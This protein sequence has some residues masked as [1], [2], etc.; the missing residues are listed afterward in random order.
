MVATRRGVRVSSPTTTNVEQPSDAKATP[1]TGRTRSAASRSD[2]PTVNVLVENSGQLQETDVATSLWTSTL[3]RCTRASRLH[4]PEQPCTPVGSIHEADVSDLE[5]CCSDM[6]AR[7]RCSSRR[8]PPSKANQEQET[9]ESCSSP[10]QENV[11]S[12]RKTAAASVEAADKKV[13]SSSSIVSDGEAP[14]KR[15]RR[16][17]RVNQAEEEASE[18][19]SCAS[20]VSATRTRRST[21]RRPI[22]DPQQEGE[23]KDNKVD[24]VP[25]TAE[26]YQSRRKSVCTRRSAKGQQED[27]ELSDAESNASSVLDAS[28]SA[29]RRSTRIRKPICPIP[30]NLD[31]VSVS[32]PTLRRTRR[33]KTTAAEKSCDSESFDSGPDYSVS[34][35]AKTRSSRSKTTESDSDLTEGSG[36]PCSSRTGSGSSL[37]RAPASVMKDLVVVLENTVEECMMDNSVL[38]S[39]VVA[40]DADGTLLDKDATEA[41]EEQDKKVSEDLSEAAQVEDPLEDEK[42]KATRRGDAMLVESSKDVEEVLVRDSVSAAAVVLTSKRGEPSAEEN[43]DENTSPVEVMEEREPSSTEMKREDAPN[44]G[45][46]LAEEHSVS[47]AAVASTDQQGELSAEETKEGDTSAVEGMEETE[48]SSTQTRCEDVPGKKAEKDEIINI[49]T[50]TSCDVSANHEMEDMDMDRPVIQAAEATPKAPPKRKKAAHKTFSL[51][52]SS[53]DDDDEVEEEDDDD[54]SEEEQDGGERRS[55]SRKPKDTVASV[56]G[57]FMVDTR[58][59]EEVDED[60]LL[61]R[62]TKEELVGGKDDEEEEFVDEEGDDNG[63]ADLNLSSKNRWLKKMS[64]CIDP[65]INMKQLGGLYITFDGSKSNS[66]PST[67]KKQKQKKV[68]DEVMKKSVMGPDFEKKD[69]VPPYSESK[70]VLKQKH[71]VEREKSTGDGWFN[72]KAPELTKELQ[73]DLQLLKM[74]GSLDPKRFYKKNDRDGFPKY[75]QV[76]T[77]VDN[78]VDFYHSRLPKKQRKRTMVEELLADAEFRHKN[79][80]KYQDIMAEKAAQAAGKHKYKKNQFHKKSK[81]PK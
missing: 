64:S 12:T 77:V 45:A 38:E 16:S 63:E 7:V 70:H 44:D 29:V 50:E 32:S 48:P 13:D 11:R 14:M 69:A 5:S 26:S 71:R 80:K 25:E 57:L 2:S 46:F 35:W 6:E 67:S 73:G 33:R 43:Q 34:T 79:K 1:A 40:E 56:E 3:K 75:F 59:G 23:A 28:R 39:T 47:E 17:R 66:G 18:A 54:F 55:L 61:E 24:L 62:L 15:S 36:T 21:R 51:T 19:E 72:M 58:A 10:V 76:G 30:M 8:R 27:S 31:E 4:S 65:G 81:V 53:D 49:Q 74:R 60:Y 9:S 52:V 37:R 78:P 42:K 22:P 20:S 41:L 68:Q